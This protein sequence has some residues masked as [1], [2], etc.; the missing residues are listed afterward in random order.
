MFGFLLFLHLSGMAVWLGSLIA[1]GIML[2]MLGRQL[3]SE[4]SRVLVRKI[5]KAF[6]LLTHP[7]SFIVL[8]SGGLMIMKMGLGDDKPFWMVY[9]ERG[10]G[11]IILL[12]IVVLS[13]LGRKMLK[14]LSAASTTGTAASTVSV[15]SAI[16]SRF[17]ASMF[18]TAFLVVS[19]VY[20]VST[21]L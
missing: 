6:N 10:G 13:I 15:P 18:V 16:T 11:M 12:S 21:K 3:H 2:I 19:V 1:V 7:S 4:E 14:K 8:L 20:V 9:M 5:V 17:A